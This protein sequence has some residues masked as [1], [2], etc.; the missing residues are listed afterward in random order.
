[1]EV[2]RKCFE[3]L[4]SVSRRMEAL[5]KTDQTT[6]VSDM[7]GDRVVEFAFIFRL[8]FQRQYIMRER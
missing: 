2:L 1:M 6:E 4:E 8:P 3:V 7:H 5:G